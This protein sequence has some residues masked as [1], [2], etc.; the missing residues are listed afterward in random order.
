M[1]VKETLTRE[2]FHA[3]LK[4][5]YYDL[6]RA[7]RRCN[8]LDESDPEESTKRRAE[9]HQ[10]LHGLYDATAEGKRPRTFELCEVAFLADTGDCEPIRWLAIHYPGFTV[11]PDAEPELYHQGQEVCG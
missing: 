9:V 1:N 3:A 4:G 11:V 7:L 5:D 2:E 6:S 10:A 8:S